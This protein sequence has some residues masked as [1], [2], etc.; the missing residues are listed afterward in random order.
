MKNTDFILI[1]LTTLVA[2]MAWVFFDAY[3]AYTT[4]RITPAL[5]EIAITLTPQ[6]DRE[7]IIGLNE[8]LVVSPSGQSR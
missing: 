7:T 2:A 1:S 6:I 4:S 5:E 8:R 3:H